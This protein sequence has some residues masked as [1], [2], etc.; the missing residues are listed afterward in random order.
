[1]VFILAAPP[2]LC[3]D[4]RAVAEPSFPPACVQ[5]A[6]KLTAGPTG[7]DPAAESSPD[8]ARIQNSL[9]ACTAGQALELLPAGPNNAF[10]MG[11]V[12]LPKGVTLLVDAGVTV[13][14]SRNPRDYDSDARQACGTLQTSS[15]GCVPLIT[16]KRA[17][18]AGLMGYGAIDGRGHLP[19]MPG[20]VAGASSWWDLAN[21]AQ[22]Q[23]LSQNC[24]RLLDVNTTNGFTLYKITLR[25]SPNFHVTLTSSTNVTAWGVKI[26][27]PYD[28]RNTDGIDQLYSSNVTI[29]NSWISTGDDDVALNGS[30]AAFNVSVVNNHFGDGHGASIG[31]YTASGVSNVLFDG[32]SFAGNALNSNQ[33][34]IRIKSDVSRGGLV[35]N[36]TYS[37]ICMQ[38]VRSPIHLDPFYTAGVTGNLVP[39]FQ[40]ITLRNVHATTEGLVKIEG[41]DATAVTTIT[42]DNVQV[43]N[44]KPSDL[45]EQY[46]AYTLG[47]GAVN[48]AAM[49]QGTGVTVANNVTGPPNPYPC[50][51]AVF[52]PV[53]AELVPGPAVIA[54]GQPLPLAVQVFPTKAVPY[55]TYLANLRANPNA[56][57]SLAAP[58]GSVTVYEGAASLAT[59]PLNGAA[60]LP[61]SVAGLSV[62]SHTLTVAY[63]GDADYAPLVFGSYTVTVA[64]SGP[65]PA[66][67]AG[68]VVNAA[69]YRAAPGIA[70]GSLFSV[71]GTNL[72]PPQGVQAAGYPLPMSLAGTSAEIA[73]AG[74]R[75][76]AWMVFAS[77]GQVNAILPS[78]VPPGAAQVT[79]TVNG[80][81]S[82]PAPVTIVPSAPGMFFSRVAGVDFAVAQNVASAT[83]YPVNQ[84]ASPA[85]PGQIVLLWGTGLGAIA[86]ADNTAPGAAGDMTALPVAITAGGLPAQRFYAGRQSQFAGA[87]NVY[88]TVPAG[89]PFGCQV[90]VAITAAGVAANTV[91]IAITADGAACR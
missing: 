3:Q 20:G 79:V 36:I 5:L 74:A 82:P 78:T 73:A 81:A 4:A 91:N 68:G 6:A 21:Q 31:S 53:G 15:S 49:L 13:F 8:T 55:Q 34:G 62:G 2:A 67:A 33:G 70:P 27:T 86:G 23:S 29:A 39:Q 16:A 24:P 76:D 71:F 88:L 46:T 17:D 43:D 10:L 32:I 48:F 28:A 83:D 85:R 18:G 64:S 9:N 63:S 56:T 90:P 51:A 65:A 77:A 69:S 80:E 25:N 75:F 50:P 7:L 57:L 61:L 30:T 22:A 89:V 84:A 40:N 45:T 59:A 54:A 72:G 37:N 19:I 38:N 26:V 47:P 12:Q 66:I 44:I 60:V 87:D 41:H 35:E 1:V 58:T 11:P 42:L 52:S 14:A